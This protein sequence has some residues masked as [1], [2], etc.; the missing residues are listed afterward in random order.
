MI[1]P[2][3]FRFGTAEAVRQWEDVQLFT[4]FSITSRF[5]AGWDGHGIESTP[6]DRWRER[7]SML[8]S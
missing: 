1:R 5:S 4:L 8:A 3:V 2:S 7:N 6:E